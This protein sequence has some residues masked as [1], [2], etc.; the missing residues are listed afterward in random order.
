MN[1]F[2]IQKFLSLIAILSLLAC[3]DNAKTQNTEFIETNLLPAMEMKS[4]RGIVF[5]SLDYG[6][7]WISMKANLPNDVQ[8]SFIGVKNNDLILATEGH[9][10][11]LKKG[12]ESLWEQIGG[13]LPSRKITALT[14]HKNEIFVGVYKAGIFKSNNEGKDWLSLNN[15]LEDLSV[16]SI[17]LFDNSILIGQ[18]FGLAKANCSDYLWEEVYK[19]VQGVEIR[20]SGNRLLAGTQKGILL[21]ENKGQNWRF[22]SKDKSIHNLAVLDNQ[23]VGM[24]ISQGTYFSKDWGASWQKRDAGM[25]NDA[26]V[27]DMVLVDDVLVACHHDGIYQSINWGQNW[28]QVYSSPSEKIKEFVANG[29]IIY[30]VTVD[31]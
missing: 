17:L 20:K 5:Q 11:F 24:Y 23:I 7:T 27:F 6:K 22:I 14:I 21:S 8:A 3:N 18:N 26:Y 25:A 1:S 30:G 31:R 12:N 13:G 15:N 16:C 28:T 9:G 4:D 19:G 10:L 29:S 2:P